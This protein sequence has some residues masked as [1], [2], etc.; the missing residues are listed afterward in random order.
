MP[1]MDDLVTWLTAQ[2]DDD[3]R[4][5][6]AATAGPWRHSPDKH[7]RKPGTAWFEE[8]VFAGAT[9]ASATC[10]AGTGETGDRQSMADAEHIARHDPARVLRDVEVKR[11]I[12]DIHGIIWRS[13]GWLERDGDVLDEAYEELPVCV[14][15]VAKHSSFPTRDAVPV[16]PCRYVRLLASPYSDRPGYREE[17]KLP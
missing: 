14:A 5:A 13:I 8:A 10:V 1:V 4:V 6:R 17:W 15:C 7:W 3:E 2:L 16:G 11:Q 12:L 9:G